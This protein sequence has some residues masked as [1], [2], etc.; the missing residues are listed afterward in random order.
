[1]FDT[2]VLM[3]ATSASDT[4]DPAPGVE[5]VR[6]WINGLPTCEASELELFERIRVLEELKAQAAAAQARLAVNLDSAVRHRH[7][8]LKVP[9]AQVGRG[10]PSQVAAARRESPFRGGRHLGFAKALVGE[11]PHTLAAM[12]AGTLSEWRATILA[13]ET[14]CLSAEDRRS[15]DE[16]LLADPA[17]VESW[18]DRRLGAEAKKLADKLDPEAQ[19][20]RNARATADRR[21]SIRPSPDTMAIISALLPVAQGVAVWA[22][23]KTVADALLGEGDERTRGQIMADTLVERVT[24]QEK[25]EVVPV[26]V[27]LTVSDETLLEGGHEPAWLADY[28]P[29]PASLARRMV[30]T[31]TKEAI[32][33]LR[34]LYVAATGRLVAMD[35]I[36]T[37]FPRGLARFIDLRDQT[38]RTPWCDAP[39]RH[40]DHVRSLLAGGET[41]EANGQGLCEQCNYA[42]EA[43]GWSA[44]PTGPPDQP[45]QV[46]TT[47]P[48]GHTLRSRSPDLPR[49]SPLR[50]R[51]V[52]VE[53]YEPDIKLE[54]DFV[55]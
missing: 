15:I 12:E 35:S 33:T 10:V 41:T 28:G 5:D 8:E 6:A 45:H 37:V 42:K 34:R 17:K 38:C 31:A 46:E 22:A 7:E 51:V 18:G 23:L 14:A 3:T 21:V 20:K 16:T 39:I 48:T 40:H 1:M 43:P 44:R 13:R 36:T 25:A 29:V 24:G 49:P 11:M 52:D 9:A 19:V 53:L 32:A 4:R 55:A 50:S 54:L 30:D 47:L 26:A 2:L 27:N